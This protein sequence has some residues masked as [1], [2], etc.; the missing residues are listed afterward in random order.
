VL[1]SVGFFFD[2]ALSF[3]GSALGYFLR[4]H[5]LVQAVQKWVFASLLIGFG[6]RLALS[7]RP[8]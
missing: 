2:A 8:Q 6:A 5:P 3:A 1:V 7:A 4:R